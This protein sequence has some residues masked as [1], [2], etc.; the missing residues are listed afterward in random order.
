MDRNST[1]RTTAPSTLSFK[2]TC[3]PGSAFYACGDIFLG[4]C[5]AYACTTKG[6]SQGNL[7]PVAFEPAQ[8]GKFPDASCGDG[9]DFWTCTAGPTF[10]GCCKSNPCANGGVCPDHDLTGA[11]VGNP[12][13]SAYYL[14]GVEVSVT[15]TGAPSSTLKTAVGMGSATA[16]TSASESSTV[17]AIPVNQ[18]NSHAGAVAG[19]AAA[20]GVVVALLVCWLI[21]YVRYIRHSR[22]KAQVEDHSG[23]TQHGVVRLREQPDKT[24]SAH[25]TRRFEHFGPVRSANYTPTGPPGYAS[26]HANTY[27]YHANGSDTFARQGDAGGASAAWKPGHRMQPSELE[28]ETVCRSELESPMSPRGGSNEKCVQPE[29]A[30]RRA[31]PTTLEARWVEVEQMLGIHMVDEEAAVQAHVRPMRINS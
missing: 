21:Y 28:G 17:S 9:A 20:G 29:A 8:Y 5:S 14:E 13:Q 16:T 4:C 23:E 10:W 24:G 7:E 22:A 18:A 26:P 2:P 11:F 1:T 27:A 12:V 31:R 30:V 19:G 15:S 25:E 3:P 6:C